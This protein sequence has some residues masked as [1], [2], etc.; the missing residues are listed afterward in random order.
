[1]HEFSSLFSD[2]HCPVSMSITVN[3]ASQLPKQKMQEKVKMPILWKTEHLER[4]LDKFDIL[5]LS[6]KECKFDDIIAIISQTIA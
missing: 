5:K 6:E 1:M 2:A 3:L 4:Y